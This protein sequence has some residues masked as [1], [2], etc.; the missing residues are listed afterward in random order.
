MARVLL[1]VLFF[2]SSVVAAKMDSAQLEVPP[3]GLSP[4]YDKKFGYWFMDNFLED[5]DRCVKENE[6]DAQVSFDGMAR[7]GP[8]GV[9]LEYHS[10]QENDFARCLRAILE[11]KRAPKPPKGVQFNPFDWGGLK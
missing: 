3:A 2:Y 1:I 7:V 5:L 4:E 10:E 8:N 9:I 11:G 6:R